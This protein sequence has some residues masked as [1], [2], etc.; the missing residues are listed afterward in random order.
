MDNQ[1]GRKMREGEGGKEGRA[2]NGT[3]DNEDKADPV[4]ASTRPLLSIF[5]ALTSAA[6]LHQPMT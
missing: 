2:G 1:E 6:P 3:E 4:R 5:A